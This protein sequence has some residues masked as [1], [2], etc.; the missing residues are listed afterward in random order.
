MHWR[1]HWQQA[2]IA[3]TTQ[4]AAKNTKKIEKGNEGDLLGGRG[5]A[6]ELDLDID[7]RQIRSVSLDTAE[8]HAK[9]AAPD[10]SRKRGTPA[11]HTCGI[12][13]HQSVFDR[14]VGDSGM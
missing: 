10:W 12:D 14:H 11:P 4:V 2:E 5:G 9:G 7:L 1:R 6:L 13:P 3:K 8:P